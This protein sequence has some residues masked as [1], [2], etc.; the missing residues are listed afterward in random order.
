MIKMTYYGE[1]GE[2]CETNSGYAGWTSEYNAMGDCIKQSNFG[3]DMQP[4]T[5]NANIC[6]IVMERDLRG[7]ITKM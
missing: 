3:T 7:N 1:D 2:P 6:S 4:T 5:S